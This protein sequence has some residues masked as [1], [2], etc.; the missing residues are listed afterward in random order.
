[1][2]SRNTDNLQKQKTNKQ[3]NGILKTLITMHISKIPN[4][5]NLRRSICVILPPSPSLVI[6]Q[7]LL[8]STCQ[9]VCALFNLYLCLISY[10]VLSKARL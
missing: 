3:K 10:R 2:K 9:K 1:M 4:P 7:L 5:N 8:I 6:M